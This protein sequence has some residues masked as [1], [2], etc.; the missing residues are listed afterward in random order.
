LVGCNIFTVVLPREWRCD[1]INYFYFQ[2]WRKKLLQ[3]QN[4]YF[5]R[6]FWKIF[7]KLQNFT[8]KNIHLDFDFRL[9]TFLRR[10]FLI[11]VLTTC[12]HLMINSSWYASQWHKIRKLKKN[13]HCLAGFFLDFW[14][15]WPCLFLFREYF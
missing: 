6:F 5:F 10:F 2:K 4:F 14:G 13:N 9:V 11:L 12:C 1:Y 7:T 3:S 8:K 15:F